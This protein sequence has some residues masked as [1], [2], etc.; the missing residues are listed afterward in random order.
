MT[1]DGRFV[2]VWTVAHELSTADTNGD[3]DVYVRDLTTGITLRASIGTLDEES[4]GGSQLAGSISEDAMRI[5]F[6]AS[7]DGIVSAGSQERHAFLRRRSM[8]DARST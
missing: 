7:T 4:K 3:E 6:V 1:S 8:V 5:A 2:V